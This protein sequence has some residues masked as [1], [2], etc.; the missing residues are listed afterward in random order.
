MQRLGSSQTRLILD[1][2]SSRSMKGDRDAVSRAGQAPAA[3]P[4]A[5]A[6]QLAQWRFIPKGDAL[7]PH[8]VQEPRTPRPRALLPCPRARHPRSL[9]LG[10]PPASAHSSNC[11]LCPGLPTRAPRT[12]SGL[13]LIQALPLLRFQLL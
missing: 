8:P 2:R 13:I 7:L 9:D 11:R 4:L 1:V 12:W 3:W 6:T 10:P 5:P